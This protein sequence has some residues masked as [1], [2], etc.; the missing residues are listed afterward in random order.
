METTMNATVYAIHAPIAD[1]L[2]RVKAEMM[3]R[4]PP[5]IHVVDCGDHY[6]AL[7][8]SHRLAAA[9]A[10]ELIPELIIH[11][12]DELIEITGYDWYDAAN[13]SGE[14]Y[15]AGEVAGELFSPHQ[16]IPY[17]FSR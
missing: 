13:W 6:M 4:G 16:A 9:Q 5:T 11:D 14:T 8:G 12:Q 17:S 7:E 3:E 1:K 10:L 15:P 2:E